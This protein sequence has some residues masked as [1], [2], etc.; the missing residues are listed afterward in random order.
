MLYVDNK[1]A[2]ACLLR[3]VW[4]I[5]SSFLKFHSP[6]GSLK[7][8]KKYKKYGKYWLYCTWNRE[9]VNAYATDIE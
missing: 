1:L 8:S 7:I 3:T 4:P 2:I 6:E 5:F 9:I